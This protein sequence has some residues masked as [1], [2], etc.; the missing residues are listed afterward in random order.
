M[1][2]CKKELVRI[3]LDFMVKYPDTKFFRERGI[4]NK[5]HLG[6]DLAPKNTLYG[7]IFL[8]SP[9][10]GVIIRADKH[11]QYGYHVRIK[12]TSSDKDYIHILAHMKT[13]PVVKFGAVVKKGTLLGTMGSTG[14]STARHC[15]YEVRLPGSLNRVDPKTYL[16]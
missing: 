9:V 1:Y 10:D 7:D 2:I 16:T 3:S 8:S 15:H 5:P 4:A 11:P 14:S 6:V 13:Q 12:S